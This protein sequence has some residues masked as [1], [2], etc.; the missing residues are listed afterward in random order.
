MGKATTGGVG[1]VLTILGGG[2]IGAGI[3][4]SSPWTVGVGLFMIGAGLIVYFGWS[5]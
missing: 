3:S 4:I 5:K 1:I 2:V